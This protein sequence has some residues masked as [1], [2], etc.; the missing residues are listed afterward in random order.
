MRW[1]IGCWLRWLGTR[2]RFE[3]APDYLRG[4]DSPHSEPRGPPKF[5]LLVQ[6]ASDEIEGVLLAFG[7]PLL[8]HKGTTTNVVAQYRLAGSDLSSEI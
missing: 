8:H 2:I 4:V 7:W 3:V 1:F 6:P 5:L